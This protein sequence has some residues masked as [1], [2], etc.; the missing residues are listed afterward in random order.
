MVPT[1]SGTGPTGLLALVGAAV[2]VVMFGVLCFCFGGRGLG[3]VLG[4]VGAV[5]VMFVCCVVSGVWMYGSIGRSV[6]LSLL[7]PQYAPT[8]TL[9]HPHTRTPIRRRRLAPLLLLDAAAG[10]VREGV[11][12]RR[13]DLDFDI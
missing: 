7:L 4:L 9:A 5:A 10:E 13:V 2:A 8:P 6:S 12:Q 1:E 11:A 3:C